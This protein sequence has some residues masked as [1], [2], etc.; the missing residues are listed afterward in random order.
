[1]PRYSV[2]RGCVAAEPAALRGGVASAGRV[3]P[4]SDRIMYGVCPATLLVSGVNF[5]AYWLRR[6]LLQTLSGKLTY[7]S[8]FREVLKPFVVFQPS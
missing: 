4:R 1:M 3:G 7:Q 2:Q 5:L 6:L 8:L